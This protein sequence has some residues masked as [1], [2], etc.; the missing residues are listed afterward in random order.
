MYISDK[1][2]IQNALIVSVVCGLIETLTIHNYDNVTI[3]VM[4]VLTYYYVK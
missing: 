1:N 4:A 2:Y 3:A